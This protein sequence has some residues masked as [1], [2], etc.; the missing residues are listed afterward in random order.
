MIPEEL[1]QFLR[2][3]IDSVEQLEIL[4]LLCQSGDRSWTAEEIARELRSS[5]SSVSK[6]LEE[7]A[8]KRF[9]KVVEQSPRRYSYA[10]VDE[11][12]RRRIE[13]LRELY[14]VRRVTVID[15]IFSKP[16]DKIKVFAD[17]F[18]FRKE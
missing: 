14:K 15:A 13:E 7:F 9:L 18:K 3:H 8:S 6:R 2:D 11:S 4:I 5:Q 10:P 1:L 12:A 16:V 17:A